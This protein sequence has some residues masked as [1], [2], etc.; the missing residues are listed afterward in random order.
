MGGNCYHVMLRFTLT[1]PSAFAK[2]FKRK[3]RRFWDVEGGVV[4]A[5]LSFERPQNPSPSTSSSPPSGRQPKPK[6]P[7]RP[8]PP[9]A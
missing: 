8:S 3:A 1:L 7:H 5:L 2:G 9:R 4:G 6:I